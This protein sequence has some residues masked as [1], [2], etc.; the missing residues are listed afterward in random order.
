MTTPERMKNG[1][2]S[3]V[4]EL[5]ELIIRSATIVSGMPKIADVD[6]AG[7]QHRHPDADACEQQQKEIEEE[8]RDLHQSTTRFRRA[9]WMV[10]SAA[11]GISRKTS[12]SA[13][14]TGSAR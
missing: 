14:G 6:D 3:S 5:S 11:P 10:P 1:T 4:K 2:A 9:A 8:K 13:A 12:A 7:E